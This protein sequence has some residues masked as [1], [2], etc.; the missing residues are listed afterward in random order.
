MEKW[1][2]IWRTAIAKRLGTDALRVL[3]TALLKDDPRLIQ[4]GTCSPPPM[5]QFRDCT[6]CGGCIIGFAG[7][8]TLGLQ[9]VGE[10][11]DYF[12]RVCDECGTE[13]DPHAV[14]YF[15]NWADDAPRREMRR[16]MLAEIR[17][18]LAV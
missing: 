12:H 2:K 9:T 16:E 11:H 17:L 1:R 13:D 3:Q 14:R 15:L 8:Q 4:G 5:D 7:W 18:A 10:V 6:I